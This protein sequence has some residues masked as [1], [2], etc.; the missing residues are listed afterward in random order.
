M[1]RVSSSKLEATPDLKTDLHS[2]GLLHH[3]KRTPNLHELGVARV[4]QSVMSEE[5]NMLAGHEVIFLF[6]RCYPVL[7]IQ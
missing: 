7:F 3:N 6:W 4:P 5:K 1:R 2:K